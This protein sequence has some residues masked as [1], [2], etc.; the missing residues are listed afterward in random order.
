MGYDCEVRHL[1]GGD[2]G[3]ARNPAIDEPDGVEKLRLF[4]RASENRFPRHTPH[5]EEMRIFLVACHQASVSIETMSKYLGLDSD[6]IRT[7][8]LLG[9]AAWNAA[10]RRTNDAAFK[11]G[12][13]LTAS[14]D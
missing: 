2:P 7:E 13:R 5:P 9:I 11:P 1:D 4:A 14:C 6:V 12:L 8:L 10:Q 3:Y